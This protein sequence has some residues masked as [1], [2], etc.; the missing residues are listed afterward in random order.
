MEG[1]ELA[2]RGHVVR[3]SEDDADALVA[4]GSQVGEGLLDG[5][6]VVGGDGREA[7]VRDG[8][9]DQHDRHAAL[10]QLDEVLVRR[11]RLG[12][13]ATGEDHARHL[14]LEQHADVLR[15]ATDRRPYACTGRG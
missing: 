9:V 6:R 2:L 5:D 7:E 1:L 12:V 4:K 14:L 3:R 13:G 10:V 15:L 8:R 11:V